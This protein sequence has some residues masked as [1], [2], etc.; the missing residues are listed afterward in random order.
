MVSTKVD[1]RYDINYKLNMFSAKESFRTK[2][3]CCTYSV[4][5]MLLHGIELPCLE[6]MSS[7]PLYYLYGII[8]WTQKE[9]LNLT[10]V[11]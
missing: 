6:V 9:H 4:A 11:Y 1:I 7:S 3:N 2:E 5:M 10:F 8:C